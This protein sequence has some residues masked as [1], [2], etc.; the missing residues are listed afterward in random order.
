[1]IDDEL[2][3]ETLTKCGNDL[4]KSAAE[5]IREANEHGGKDNI[6]AIL[7]RPVKSFPAGNSLFSRFFDI[8]S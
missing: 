6:S 1:M 3:Q 2:I 4:D 7:V 5:L 8:F